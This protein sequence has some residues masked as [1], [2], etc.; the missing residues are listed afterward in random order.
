MP[1]SA[2]AIPSPTGTC[3]K[4]APMPPSAPLMTRFTPWRYC[5]MPAETPSISESPMARS[6]AAA[7]AS[8]S[9]A[10]SPTSWATPSTAMAMD[11]AAT[12]TS[13]TLPLPFNRSAPSN[14]LPTR[15]SQPQPLSR[16]WRPSPPAASSS[17]GASDRLTPPWTRITSVTRT[18]GAFKPT[19]A[20]SSAS[21]LT[22]PTA[23]PIPISN[24]ITRPEA[25][26]P[27]TTPRALD[28]E[29]SSAATPPPLPE[30][31]TSASARNTTALPATTIISASN[32]PAVSRWNPTATTATTSP[33]ATPTP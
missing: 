20:M 7:I 8:R 25:R 5:L 4:P 33:T 32:W 11:W 29:P 15:R 31:I 23:P 24:F 27:P 18:G 10:A 6:P 9:A 28:Q 3:A 14:R 17:A 1:Q 2:P 21:A 19:P 13:R 16:C 26:L 22:I 30:P 12:P